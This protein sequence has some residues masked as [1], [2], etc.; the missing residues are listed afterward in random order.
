MSNRNKEAIAGIIRNTLITKYG[1]KAE[2]DYVRKPITENYGVGFY[3]DNKS[4]LCLCVYHRE[5][6]QFSPRQKK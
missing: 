6:S 5:G 1:F 2:G 4:I 3:H